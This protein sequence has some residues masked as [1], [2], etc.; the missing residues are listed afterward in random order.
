MANRKRQLNQ[1]KWPTS[2]R[3]LSGLDALQ[4]EVDALK[5]LQ[6]EAA[7]ELPSHENNV[8]GDF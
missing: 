4:V 5:T 3:I 2:R 8:P 1:G 6:A 7:A